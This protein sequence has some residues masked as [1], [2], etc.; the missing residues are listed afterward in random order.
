MIH[1]RVP[2]TFFPAAP[3]PGQLLLRRLLMLLEPLLPAQLR[4]HL[5]EKGSARHEQGQMQQVAPLPNASARPP[6]GPVR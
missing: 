5:T 1:H 2:P 6:G 4:S 3:L